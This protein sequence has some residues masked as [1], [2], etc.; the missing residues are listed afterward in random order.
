MTGVQTCALPICFLALLDNFCDIGRLFKNWFYCFV[1]QFFATSDDFQKLGL[2]LRWTIFCDIGRL[3]KIGFVASLDSFLHFQTTL[4][5]QFLP[6][7][8]LSDDK[9]TAHNMGLW[10][11]GRTEVIELWEFY[12][13]FVWADGN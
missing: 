13:A 6:E 3:L 1:G 4:G 2:S 12:S 8:A 11:L 5:R 7:N 9:N 10:Q